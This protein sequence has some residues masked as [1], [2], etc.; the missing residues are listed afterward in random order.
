MRITKRQLLHIIREESKKHPAL[1]GDQDKLP[2]ELQKAIIDKADEEWEETNESFLRHKLRK[3]LREA[4][5]GDTVDEVSED[6]GSLRDTAQ[7]IRDLATNSS[8][9]FSTE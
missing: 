6:I 2:K 8:F 3:I 1:K 7:E 9:D 5:G 4:V